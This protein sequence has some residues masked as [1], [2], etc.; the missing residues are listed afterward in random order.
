[1]SISSKCVRQLK[2]G[3]FRTGSLLPSRAVYG[4][5][6]MHNYVETGAW[7]KA[8]GM[9]DGE[10][11]ETRNDAFRLAA[12][13]VAGKKVLYLE[14]GVWRGASMKFWS[15]LL[16]HP[17]AMLHGFDS[18]EG[19]P[20]DWSAG[21]GKGSFSVEGAI[22]AIDDPRVRFFKGWFDDTLPQYRP[23][24]HDVLFVNCDADLY[25]S[26]KTILTH[27]RPWL[28][29]GDYLYFDEFHHAHGERNAFEEFVQTTGYRFAVVGSS[30]CK[31]QI[32]FRREA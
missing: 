29:V 31:D 11:I 9:A 4:L 13:E 6:T 10:R 24:E 23:P 30:P 27:A 28:K 12:R 20:E 15:K 18:F 16:T 19:L 17:E 14:F 21:Y 5:Q 3:L 32:L 25:T 7:W 2:I 26:T 1:M 8:N 22:P